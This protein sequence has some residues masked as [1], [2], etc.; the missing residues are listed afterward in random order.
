MWLV[1]AFTLGIAALA[2]HHERPAER[3]GGSTDMDP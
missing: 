3:K 1:R 2:A